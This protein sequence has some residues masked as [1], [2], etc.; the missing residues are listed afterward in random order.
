MNE[1]NTLPNYLP[2][3][4][5]KTDGENAH[6]NDQCNAHNDSDENSFTQYNYTYNI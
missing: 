4:I 6:T 3:Q 2:L 1:H 5:D